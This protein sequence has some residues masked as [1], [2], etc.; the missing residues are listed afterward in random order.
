MSFCYHSKRD[1]RR[2]YNAL[3]SLSTLP[4]LPYPGGIIINTVSS[5]S[6]CTN[7]LTVSSCNVSRSN[8]AT[9][10]S[11]TRRE[12]IARVVALIG[13]SWCFCW[14]PY[15]TNLALHFWSR[16]CLLVWYLKTYW[17]PSTWW[18]FALALLTNSQNLN[19]CLCWCMWISISARNRSSNQWPLSS[20]WL[21]G[22]GGRS[23]L[24]TILKPSVKPF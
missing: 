16:T 11:K 13:K 14:L 19:C 15:T 22:S 4:C 10:A 7:S 18:L 3:F 12:I 1:Q 21:T 8:L 2:Q 24:W 5:R 9:S 20:W 23:R 17:H 6:A